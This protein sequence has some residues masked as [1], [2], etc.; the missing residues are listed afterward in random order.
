MTDLKPIVPC[1]VFTGIIDAKLDFNYQVKLTEVVG[2]PLIFIP[3]THKRDYQPGDMVTVEVTHVTRK[4]GEYLLTSARGE[5]L[6]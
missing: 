3:L 1:G 6:P 5:F 4:V 2:D